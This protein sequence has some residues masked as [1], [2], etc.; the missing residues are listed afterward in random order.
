LTEFSGISVTLRN[1]H[2]GKRLVSENLGAGHK[3]GAMRGKWPHTYLV[4]SSM[5][6]I[7]MKIKGCYIAMCVVVWL[8]N[9]CLT[10]SPGCNFLREKIEIV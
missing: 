7:L 2:T 3:L 5:D 6:E 10:Q 1:P 4:G 9:S 8:M